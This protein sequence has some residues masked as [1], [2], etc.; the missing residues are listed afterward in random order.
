MFVY[1]LHDLLDELTFLMNINDK[2]LK[3]TGFHNEKNTDNIL[4]MI[5]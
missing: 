4:K 3:V 2:Q 5:I 1:Y